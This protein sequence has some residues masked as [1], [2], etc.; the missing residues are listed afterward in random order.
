MKKTVTS[1]DQKLEAFP[2]QEDQE[3]PA[4]HLTME[5]FSAQKLH[6]RK[7]QIVFQSEKKSTYD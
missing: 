6:K 2:G 7:A 3:E 5:C 1:S 4:A